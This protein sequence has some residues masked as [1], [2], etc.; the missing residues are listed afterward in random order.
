MTVPSP[1]LGRLENVRVREIWAHEA[2]AFTP[3]LLAN[4]ERLAEAPGIEL[5]LTHREHAGG[6]RHLSHTRSDAPPA[7]GC[8]D[9]Q[10]TET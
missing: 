8:P 9:R 3:G 6:G 2:Q 5:E 1:A 7:P 10:P 4:G